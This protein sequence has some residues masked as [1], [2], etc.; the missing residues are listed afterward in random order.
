MSTRS[1]PWPAGT[2]CWADLA[3]TDRDASCAF[4]S[5]VLGWDFTEP[6]DEFGGYV[7][8]TVQ[9]DLVA[10]LAPKYSP[11]QAAAWTLYFATGDPASAA[12]AIVDHGGS[13]IMGPDAVRDLGT[14][15]LAVDV[16]GAAAGPQCTATRC[17]LSSASSA[18]EVSGTSPAM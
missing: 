11:D 17:G 13:L 6:R 7:N 10:G 9:G 8:A 16:T 18:S 5:A 3:V 12:T 15:V 2:P 4:Y 1:T 14:I